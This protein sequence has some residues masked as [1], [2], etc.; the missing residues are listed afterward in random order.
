MDELLNDQAGILGTLTLS[1]A[2]QLLGLVRGQASND[3]QVNHTGVRQLTGQANNPID[4][5]RASLNQP[6]VRLTPARFGELNQAANTAAINP[7]FRGL[8]PRTISNLIGAQQP[9]TAPSRQ[10]STLFMAFSQ[11]FDH[12]LDF[13]PKGGNGTIPIGNQIPGDRNN[14]ADLTRGTIAGWT[15]GLPLFSNLDTPYVDQNQAYGPIEAVGQLLRCS[16]GNQGFGSQLLFSSKPDPSAPGFCLLPTLRELLNTHIAAASIF[17]TDQGAKTLLEYYPL[18]QDSNGNYNASEVAKLAKNFVGSGYNLLIDANPSINALDHIISGDGR[19]NENV[20]LT[21]MHTVWVRNHNYHAAQLATL[22]SENGIP[23]SQEELFQAAKIVNEAEYQRVIFTE[24]AQTMLGG[25]GI[26]GAG[27]HG[28]QD[29]KPEADASISLEFQSMAYRLG[30]T[31]I[32]NDLWIMDANGAPQPTP[33]FDL[34]LNP[35]NDPSAF[36]IDHDRNPATA[37]LTGQAALSALAQMGYTPQPGY[38]Q[39]GTGAILAGIAQQPAE[40]VDGQMVDA[41]RNDLVRIR[42]DLF[43]QNVARGWDLGMGTLNQI[44]QGLLD[45]T[46][47]YVQEAIRYVGAAQL[48]PYSSWDDFQ[49]RNTLSDA[50]IAQFRQAYPDLVL[51]AAE[52]QTFQ[53]FNPEI[54]AIANGDNSFTVKGVDRVDGW[55]GGLVEA[56]VDLDHQGSPA[57]VGSTFW[58]ILHEQ[59]DRLQEADRF[60]YIPRLENLPLYGNFVEETTFAKI[61][62]RNTGLT[63]LP[64]SVFGVF[65]AGANG[66]QPNLADPAVAGTFSQAGAPIVTTNAGL[67][68]DH[69]G[70]INTLGAGGHGDGMN[71]DQA[72]ALNLHVVKDPVFDGDFPNELVLR[73]FGN[74]EERGSKF[75]LAITAA[76]LRQA[77]IN[78]LDF[79]LHLGETFGE[80]FK[81]N[82]ANVFFSDAMA[83]QRRVQVIENDHGNGPSIRFEG[84]GL[85]DLGIGQSIGEATSEPT[86]LAYIEL[87]PLT[88]IDSLIKQARGFDQYGFRNQETFEVPLHFAVDANVDQVVFSDLLSLR[89]LGGRDVLVNPV[90]D[91]TARA[92]QA[93][94]VTTSSFDLGTARQIIKPDEIGFTNLIRKGDTILQTSTWQNTGEFTF[95]NLQIANISNN[96]AT[97]TSLFNDHSATQAELGWSDLPG[98][99]DIATITSSFHITGQAGSVLDTTK[100]GFRLSA[101]GDY[102]WNTTE[103]NQF[104][105]KHLITWQGDLNYD[106]AVTMKDLAFL[107]AGAATGN[108]PHD[109]DANFDGAI[110]LLD[111]AVLDADWGKTLHTGDG[112]FTGSQSISMDELLSQGDKS[113]DSSAFMLQNSIEAIGPNGFGQEVPYVNVLTNDS[114]GLIS[115]VQGFNNAPTDPL[116]QQQLALTTV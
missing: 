75:Y 47:P 60:Y 67:D 5:N 73:Q 72:L 31:M 59:L 69:N 36:S 19:D 32:P 94:L 29:Y 110:N 52:W 95:T 97:V 103:M 85:E 51:T 46:S 112:T 13:L 39:L 78:T 105:T 12:G 81:L 108:A 23:L 48:Q 17:S 90:L 49:S 44:K 7:I 9:D 74:E 22:Y 104:A 92:A 50:V 3:D 16:D 15:N 70:G 35:T 14:P 106:G 113:W 109:V 54:S 89:D 21:A 84:A 98:A 34:F 100:A 6:F 96:V 4:P 76:S 77:N 86:V 20:S 111:L 62:A 53:G 66:E 64:A 88:N 45:S 99:G 10:A 11:Y 26:R 65:N 91:L 80:V 27:E 101:D 116:E 24:F 87:Q 28:F 68:G 25:Q 8:D 33:L 83:A 41:V 63:N 2:Q 107:N 58:V 57:L 40:E 38:S 56:K 55:V 71:A 114:E 1:D 37:P 115:N 61:I 79:T 82:A 18:L 43:S 30:H 42:A 93:G 102:N